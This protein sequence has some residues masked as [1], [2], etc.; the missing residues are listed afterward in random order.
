M[1][2]FHAAPPQDDAE[3]FAGPDGLIDME[4][5]DLGPDLVAEEDKAPYFTLGLAVTVLRAFHKCIGMQ[6]T[7]EVWKDI[8][9]RWKECGK[10]ETVYIEEM[11]EELQRRDL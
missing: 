8:A 3:A 4:E 6:R 1:P 5:E 10:E 2:E 7:L 9:T 11:L